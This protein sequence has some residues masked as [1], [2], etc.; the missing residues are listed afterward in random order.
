[1]LRTATIRRPRE[2]AGVPPPPDAACQGDDEKNLVCTACIIL[3]LY[4]AKLLNSRAGSR[5]A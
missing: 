3:F 4:D 2:G 1:M 5:P